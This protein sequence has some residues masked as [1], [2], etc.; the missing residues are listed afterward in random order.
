MARSLRNRCHLLMTA[1]ALAVHGRFLF[2]KISL[3]YL[4]I[5]LYCNK[6]LKRL[7]PKEP[8]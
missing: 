5:I 7:L 8:L 6:K 1:R 2:F 3:A 4:G